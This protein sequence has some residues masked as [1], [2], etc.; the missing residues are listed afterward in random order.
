MIKVKR[1]SKEPLKEI[2]EVCKRLY[3]KKVYNEN[4]EDDQK[5]LLELCMRDGNVSVLTHSNVCVE[6]L[7]SMFLAREL[8][9]CG[10]N[11]TVQKSSVE[12]DKV[13]FY[14]MDNLITKNKSVFNNAYSKFCNAIT[15]MLNMSNEHFKDEL[16]IE[17]FIP[18]C[19]LTTVLI[20]ANYFEWLKIL[21]IS[22][23]SNAT[24]ELKSL[25]SEL[26]NE[27]NLICPLVFNK[28]ML[29]HKLP[30]ELT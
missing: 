1:S 30:Q 28:G 26:M 12:K 9:S 8:T 16:E 22:Y 6:F 27:L 21:K 15:E 18:G 4:D 10:I 24:P 7:C 3:P 19:V 20:T 17:Y 25:C 5:R 29:K 13:S 2:L 14:S 23:K 11:I